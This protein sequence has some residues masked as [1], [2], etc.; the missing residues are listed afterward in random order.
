MKQLKGLMF[1]KNANWLESVGMGLMGWIYL[2]VILWNISFTLVRDF[3]IGVSVF[4]MM[5]G[6]VAGAL[7]F[8]LLFLPLM[9][10]AGF[11]TYSEAMYQRRMESASK[12]G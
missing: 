12:K 10:F 5:V 11:A 9:G 2:P 8:F 7:L 4:V 6:K 1:G 3:V